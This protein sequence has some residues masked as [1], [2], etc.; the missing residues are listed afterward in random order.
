MPPAY[1]F[2]FAA[3][4][5]RV[6][7]LLLIGLAATLPPITRAQSANS[8]ND[9]TNTT[10]TSQATGQGQGAQGPVR[11]RSGSSQRRERD[12]EPSL[13]R[14]GKR[15][16]TMPMA[17]G[18]DAQFPLQPKLPP[19]PSEFEV[20]VQ[21]LAGDPIKRFGSE[22]MTSDTEQEPE[23]SSVP[24]PSDYA[25]KV[26]DEVELALWGSVDAELLLQVDR[27]G[28]INIPRVG[29]V[30]VAGVRYAEVEKLIAQRV[31]RVFKNFQ[32]AVTLGQLRGLR[33]YVTGHV[34]RPGTYVV[35]SLATM[36]QVLMQAGGPAASGT[37]RGI[38][39]RRGSQ[40]MAT[41]DLYDL[42]LKGDRGADRTVEAGDVVHV[43]PVGREVALIG[44]VNR[45]AIFELLPHESIGDLLQMAGGFSAVADR[46]RVAIERLDERS[47]KRIVQLELPQ[48]ATAALASGDVLRAFSVVD[49]ALPV[50]RQ[51]K[52]VRI[53]GEVAR[54]GDYVLAARSTIADALKA[55]GGL[56]DAAFVYGT[57]FTRESVRVTQQQNYERAVRDLETE[58]ARYTT[59]QRTSTAD[60]AAA[61]GARAT[62]TSR[63]IDRLRAVK[64][65]GRVV[66]QLATDT[67]AL[68][69]LVLDDGDRILVPPRPTSVG[70]FGS[71]YNGGSYLYNDGR[72]V[73]DFLTLAG[74]PTRGADV[75][76]MF[77]IRANGSVIADRSD[78]RSWWSRSTSAVTEAAAEPGDTIFVPEELEKTTFIQNAKDWGLI[79]S[80]FGLGVAAILAITR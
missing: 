43:G 4:L 70:V 31:S 29:A 38:Q 3:R 66:L 54:P 33:V 23:L 21:R 61:Q 2:E 34:A 69:D 60:E 51:N 37:F 79:V 8:N 68:P 59:S 26:G 80:Q 25:L 41:V 55:A 16:Q 17:E 63:L 45:P 9:G 67:R 56:T 36:T 6:I 53:E 12:T 1:T 75:S 20:F 28:R 57:E 42:L 10:G 27:T 11:L 39:L 77:V 30:Q 24:V 71:V 14:Q 44:S 76:S 48:A 15:T 50:E 72:R 62:A 32:L 5:G 64:P 73:D 35:P 52:R 49:T 40:G 46:T 78:K 18:D 58:L 47:D 7:A 74:G 65:N 13:R 19:K 22:L